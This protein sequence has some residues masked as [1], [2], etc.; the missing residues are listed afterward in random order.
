[1]AMA[2]RTA[3]IRASSLLLFVLALVAFFEGRGG[4]W[5]VSAG[6]SAHAD[7]P[8]VITILTARQGCLDIQPPGNMTGLV[9]QA[10]NGRTSCA[11]QSPGQ[12]QN[13]ATRTFCTQ[14]LEISYRCTNGTQAV[15]NVPGDAWNHGAAQ[16]ACRPQ[17]LPSP[18]T[19]PTATSAPSGTSPPAQVP[20]VI[21]VVTARQGCL[22][23]QPAGNMTRLVGGA[24]NGRSSCSFKSPGPEPGSATRTF[25][26]QGM[27]IT[28]DCSNH[29]RRVVSVPGD[30]WSHA[31]AQL[32]C[33]PA[34]IPPPGPDP[35]GLTS[36]PTDPETTGAITV[37]SARQGCLDIQ[38]AGNMTAVVGRSC[39]GHASCDFKAPNGDQPGSVTR[40]FCTQQLEVTYRCGQ[41]GAHTISTAT[42]GT[43]DA[44]AKPPLS[45]NCDGKS[46]VATN[47]ASVT[48]ATDACV[49]ATLAPP[50]YYLPP[51]GML[52]WT[53][54][55]SKGDYTFLGFRPPDPPATRDKYTTGTGPVPNYPGA[56]GS[57]MG[58][59][60]GRLRS[61]LRALAA[62]KDPIRDLCSAAQRLT[63]NRAASGTEP[64]DRELGNAMADLAV[65]GRAAFARFVAAHPTEATLQASSSC[66][67]ASRAS[68]TAALDRAYQVA[69]ALHG[70]HDSSARRALGWIA[71]S[72]EDDQPYLPVDVPGT[73]GA[74][75]ASYPLF[76]IPVTTHGIGVTT[77][78]FIAHASAPSFPQP[79]PLLNGGVGRVIPSDPLPALAPDAE[80]IVF[81]HGMDSRAEEALDLT[82]ALH[83]QPGHNWT[84]L[85][86]DLP[87]S[88]YA[89]NIDNARI[90][91]LSA[92]ACHNTPVVDFIEDFVVDFVNAVDRQLGGQLKP[93]IRAVVG[94]SLGGNMALRLGRRDDLARLAGRMPDTPWITTVVSWSPA[95]IWPSMIARPNCVS[96][97]CD[98]PWDLFKDRAVNT[99]LK[100]AGLEAR[101]LPQNE[102]AELRRELFYGGFDWNG[103]DAVAIFSPNNHQPQAQCWFSDKYP[104][105]QSH[106]LAAR[107]DRH[108]TYDANFRSWHWRLGAEQLAFS[109]QQ[110]RVAGGPTDP[111]YLHNTK[112]TLLFTGYD[113]VCASLGEYTRQVAAKMTNTPGFARFLNATGHSLD[114]EHP[115]YVASKI[116]EYLNSRDGAMSTEVNTRRSGPDYLSFAAAS[117]EVCRSACSQQEPCREYSF[118]R[119]GGR[120]TC[121]LKSAA[122]SPT[123]DSNSTA[124]L[125]Q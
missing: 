15:A 93:R 102:T 35:A 34:L 110:N 24:C 125:K 77:R 47:Y 85:S 26:T 25:C 118:T 71:V 58:S 106:I 53:P 6:Q 19:A 108:E 72:G 33:E 63:S 80:V 120:G 38:P 115:T 31:A 100:W 39:N 23:I 114:N 28:Y 50:A 55:H 11:Y 43:G 79:A 46:L 101:F 17:T 57:V 12:Q 90:G 121:S 61:E 66:S 29:V 68:L 37:V 109:H 111:L 52:D 2:K 36:V 119:Q 107:L 112:P 22:D 44:W 97:G 98:T 20:N 78:Y 123:S 104:C 88:G 59:N 41:G 62:A 117:F 89:D 103:G 3:L 74:G 124:G 75:R 83:R 113:D 70:A 99:P 122:G 67:G 86:M 18:T 54:T 116:T 82:S 76:H 48:P 69:V 21:S 13:S 87:S 45:L 96:C 95:S 65:T 73:E 92:V 60:E 1:L 84:V 42:F 8:N 32:S 5:R 105:K 14:G 10:C 94:G 51:S 56:P 81:V 49:Q 7:V 16:L 9:A 64:S 40:T 30:A 4:R 27:E 91:P